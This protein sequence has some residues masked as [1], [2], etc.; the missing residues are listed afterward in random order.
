M[1]GTAAPRNVSEGMGCGVSHSSLP[2]LDDR[3]C[4]MPSIVRTATKWAD[5]AGRNHGRGQAYSPEPLAI[6]GIES[7]HLTVGRSDHQQT[8]VHARTTA[9]RGVRIHA[10]QPPAG[11]HVEC[12]KHSVVARGKQPVAL[13]GQPEAEQQVGGLAFPQAEGWKPPTEASRSCGPARST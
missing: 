1:T 3:A 12:G 2:F 4:R 11:V 6:G 7:D 8:A 9:E 5:T 13:H 10:P